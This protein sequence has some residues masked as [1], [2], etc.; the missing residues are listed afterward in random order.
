LVKSM[1]NKELVRWRM[2]EVNVSYGFRLI[3][4]AMWDSPQDS[5]QLE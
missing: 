4:S 5:K 3:D 1:Q 2:N